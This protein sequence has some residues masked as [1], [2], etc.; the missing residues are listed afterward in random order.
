MLKY[1]IRSQNNKLRECNSRKKF[2]N[3]YPFLLKNMQSILQRVVR[4]VNNREKIVI[5]GYYDVDSITSVSALL[6]ALR[7]LK[8]DVEYFIPVEL[9][10]GKMLTEKDIKEYIEFLGTNLVISLGCFLNSDSDKKLCDS[11]GIDVITLSSDECNNNQNK[12]ILTPKGVNSPYPFKELSC[13]GVTFKLI[14]ALSNYYK[15]SKFNKYID[16]I[17]LGTVASGKDITE[18]NNYIVSEGINQIKLSNNYG[19]RA[20]M[21]IQNITDINEESLQKLVSTIIPKVNAIGNMEN[22]KIIVELFTTL[23]KDKAEQIA[24]Y[25]YKNHKGNRI[26]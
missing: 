20:L 11:L 14:Q 24:K 6:L 17:S 7:Y 16:L 8:A 22:A 13:S 1:K 19:I 10:R 18:E 4:A 25:L 5:F 15:T 26:T 12:Y 9:D 3:Y 2:N 21:Q 23:D